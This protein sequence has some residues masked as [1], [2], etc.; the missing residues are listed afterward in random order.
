MLDQHD[1]PDQLFIVLASPV[2][3]IGRDHDYDWAIVEPSSIRSLIQLAGRIRRH[4]GAPQSNKPNIALMQTNVAHLHKGMTAPAF[5]RPGFETKLS[6]TDK[7]LL[8]SHDLNDLITDEQLARIDASA[9]IRERDSLAPRD[10]LADL[11]H[12][13]LR[14]LMGIEKIDGLP[15]TT[16][17][18]HWYQTRAHLSG[19]LQRVQPFRDETIK[20]KRYY[21]GVDD[22]DELTL[23][24]FE[25]YGPAT[26]H[27]GRL[28]LDDIE[29]GERI[30]LLGESSY[31]KALET[32][33]DRMDMDSTECERRFGVID[34]PEG[35]D[36]EPQ[37]RYHPALGFYVLPVR[38]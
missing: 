30:E 18:M 32:L 1:E 38:Q 34:L 29:P 28:V 14:M 31:Q 5:C 35:R 7:P 16:P 15:T 4:R 9:R 33:A 23:M 22:D 20:H 26:N 19:E 17:V 3:E 10:N 11:E 25:K 36:Q 37:W 6:G 12:A 2:A 8:N 24:R 13:Q 27:T 21:L